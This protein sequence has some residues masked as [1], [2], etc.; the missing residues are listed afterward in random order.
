V[1]ALV[2]G[3]GEGSAEQPSV[4][5]DPPAAEAVCARAVRLSWQSVAA[6][7][8]ASLRAERRHGSGELVVL[9]P[10]DEATELLDF[11]LGPEQSYDYRLC[12]TSTDPPS[13]SEWTSTETPASGLPSEVELTVP[14]TEADGADDLYAFSLFP[15]TQ[16]FGTGC[17]VLIDRSGT[18]V[19][20]YVDIHDGLVNEVELFAD[21]TVLFNQFGELRHIDLFHRKLANY[22]HSEPAHPN[23]SGNYDDVTVTID[24]YFH[25][26][27][28]T[29]G[30]DALLSVVFT[31]R[32]DEPT[33]RTILGDG[34]SIFDRHTG[35]ELW[36]IDLFDYYDY[37]EPD[38]H[39][40]PC[41]EDNFLG[42]GQDWT[43]ANAVWFDEQ[44]SEIYLN[45]RNLDLIAVFDYPSGELVR[46]IGDGGVTFAHSHD[47]QYLPDGT[48]LVL[49]N[50]LHRPGEEVY[51]RAVQFRPENDQL[52]VVWEYREQLDFISPAFG[53]ADRLENGHTLVTDGANGRI[54]E[55]D[56]AGAKL[57]EIE[58][59]EELQIYKCQR[60][61]G[62]WFRA[63]VGQE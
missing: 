22:A 51:S 62:P 19:W 17:V 60:L 36:F 14:Y 11:G 32:Y 27:T 42:A 8:R 23:P 53:D 56:D 55:V 58:L 39:C 29:F 37:R 12:V 25:H 3:C 31:Q 9:N 46:E 54:L 41:L 52:E 33:E 5:V 28:D 49:D 38:E 16:P 7:L 21:G 18:V 61:P 10:V 57:W 50:G 26:D 1:L 43:H 13:C 15:Y 24:R 4:A 34:V 47:P 45:V 20:E 35:E 59:V 2:A 30:S 48:V 6:E 40:A 44:Q 63:S